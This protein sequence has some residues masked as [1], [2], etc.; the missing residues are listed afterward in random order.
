MPRSLYVLATPGDRLP[1][2]DRGRE[3]GAEGETIDDTNPFYAACIADGSL[4]PA[5]EKPALQ[6]KKP[7]GVN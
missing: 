4:M 5:P 3:F 1:M 7:D 6:P 2:P